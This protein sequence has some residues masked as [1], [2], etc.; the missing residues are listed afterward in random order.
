MPDDSLAS[1]TSL[2][3]FRLDFGRQAGDLSI[4]DRDIETID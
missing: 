1:K 4:L 2:C 3:L